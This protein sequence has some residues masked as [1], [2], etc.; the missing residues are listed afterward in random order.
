MEKNRICRLSAAMG[1][2]LAISGCD[3]VNL[4]E[5]IVVPTVLRS[6]A[7]AQDEYE[8]TWTCAVPAA[9]LCVFG[10]VPTTEDKPSKTGFN[11]GYNFINDKTYVY[12]NCNCYV[13]R[14]YAALHRGAVF[15]DLSQLKQKIFFSAVISFQD[16]NGL[17][18]SGASVSNDNDGSFVK[19][20]TGASDWFKL[21]NNPPGTNIEVVEAFA[22][23]G[24]VLFDGIW[25]K[26]FD[27]DANV[28]GRIQHK[29]PLYS[30]NITKT[31][32]K[33][34]NNAAENRGLMFLPALEGLPG[35]KVTVSSA[36]IGSFWNVKLRIKYNANMKENSPGNFPGS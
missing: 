32:Q 14:Y 3:T 18:V 30:A 25:S 34:R 35:D 24:D 29:G 17:K 19:I 22:Q 36:N 4:Q 13:N 2:F 26:P 20:V 21:P 6:F 8:K 33:W 23:T 7:I 31:A 16:G 1:V 9:G 10:G 15:F 12:G 27:A 28:D 5:I 11:V